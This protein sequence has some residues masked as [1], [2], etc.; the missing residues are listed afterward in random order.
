MA[1]FG[2]VDLYPALVVS[3]ALKRGISLELIAAATSLRPATL[4]GLYPRK[5]SLRPGADGDLALFDLESH[6]KYDVST[7]LSSA[8]SSPYDGWEVG[9]AVA[10]TILRGTVVARN[11]AIVNGNQGVAVTTEAQ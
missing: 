3:E 5:G 1:G 7:T 2:S 11:G 8:K 6:W 10:A 9:A 4:F